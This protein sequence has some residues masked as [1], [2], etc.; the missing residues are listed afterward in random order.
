MSIS[1][2][3]FDKTPDGQQV[4]EFILT[5]KHGASISVIDFGG[6]VTNIIVP[7]KNGVMADVALG[8]DTIDGYLID[9][10][11]MGDTVGRYGNRIGKGQF[12]LDGISYQLACNNGA[13]HLHGGNVGFS[14]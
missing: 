12:T 7:D 11:C 10:G 2:R 14:Q 5:N 3:P 9:H 13:N 8:F 1:T 6:I 4:T